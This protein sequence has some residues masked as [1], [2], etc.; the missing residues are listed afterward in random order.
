MAPRWGQAMRRVLLA[1]VLLLAAL[2]PP[3]GAA[4]VTLATVRTFQG[5]ATLTGTL[6][7]TEC[8]LSQGPGELRVQMKDEATI[9]LAFE[10]ARPP[11][12]DSPAPCATARPCVGG[13]QSGG[14]VGICFDPL[15]RVRGR[16][17]LSPNGDGSYH[18]RASFPVGQWG[19]RVN[20]TVWPQE[21]VA[22]PR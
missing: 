13:A 14:W 6:P 10:F 1:G 15:T 20:G 7:D 2:P 3:A 11:A 18:F 19:W 17:V 16:L 22:L 5:T 8:Y 4:G 12:P 21:A 9:A